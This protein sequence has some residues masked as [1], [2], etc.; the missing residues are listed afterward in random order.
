MESLI[1]NLDVRIG[2]SGYDYPEWKGS[3][4]PIDLA[5][6]DFLGFYSESFNTLE[7][8]FTYYRQPRA[9]IFDRMLR[10]LR[11]PIDFSVKAYRTLTHDR[12]A[13]FLSTV[14]NEFRA[15][16]QP[17]I[18]AGCLAAVLLE[19]PSSFHYS[20]GERLYLARLLDALEGMPLVVELRNAEWYSARVIE[21][22]RERNVGLCILDAPRLPGLPP[23][24]DLITAD[25]AYIRFHGRNASSWWTGDAGT[26]YEYLYNPEELSAW[27]PR[28]G[29]LASQARKIRV[30]FNNHRRGNAAA[31]ALDFVRLSISSSFL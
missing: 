11:R 4:Y 13:G 17:L 3:F 9:E 12:D 1:S 24:S 25:L 19:F 16:L 22:L 5:R 30:Y 7:I 28:L 26:R 31:N 2:T 14:V 8:N 29:S 10:R 23:V 18:H 6:K 21:A 15:G 20:T 27:I